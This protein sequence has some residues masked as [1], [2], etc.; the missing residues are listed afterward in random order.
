MNCQNN[1]VFIFT[2]DQEDYGGTILHML[3]QD[4]VHN[5]E[6]GSRERAGLLNLLLWFEAL[7][8]REGVIA[9]DFCLVVAESSP[10]G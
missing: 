8:I 4:I 2:K 5:F 6:D 9:S 10:I 1:N 3:L 7:L